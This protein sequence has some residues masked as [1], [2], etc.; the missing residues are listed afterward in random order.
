MFRTHKYNVGPAEKRRYNDRTYDSIAEKDRA[1]QLDL[2]MKAGSI[3]WWCPQVV[4][5]LDAIEWRADFVVW[6]LATYEGYSGDSYSAYEC[7]VEDVKGKV[8]QRDRDI[9][10]L[11]RKH[12]PFDLHI[13]KRKRTDWSTEVIEGGNGNQD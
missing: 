12:G 8:T 9:W 6:T 1:A 7:H 3:H 11:W 4:F 10:K 5:R 13:L 2:M